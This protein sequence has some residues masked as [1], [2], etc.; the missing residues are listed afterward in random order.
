MPEHL[1]ALSRYAQAHAFRRVGLDWWEQ[2]LGQG[3]LYWFIQHALI[4]S[5]V[6]LIHSFTHSFAFT[7]RQ[8]F[9]YLLRPS[10]HSYSH[11]ILSLIH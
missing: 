5:F 2:D 3:R 1:Q 10:I 8:I 4:L 11:F 7:L 6:T 9:M